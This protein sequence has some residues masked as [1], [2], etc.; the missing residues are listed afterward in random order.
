MAVIELASITDSGSMTN[1]CIFG[2]WLNV[3]IIDDED[4]V[5]YT[6]NRKSYPAALSLV[7]SILWRICEYI[8]PAYVSAISASLIVQKRSV[9]L[10]RTR[11]NMS[12]Q[13]LS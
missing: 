2:L 3:I 13:V 10:I 1:V 9:V 4:Y 7:L 5:A 11:E 12:N 6:T 8:K